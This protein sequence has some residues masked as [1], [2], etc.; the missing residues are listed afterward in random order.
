MQHPREPFSPDDPADGEFPRPRSSPRRP[1]GPAG[2]MPLPA[3]A[4]PPAPLIPPETHHDEAGAPPPPAAAPEPPAGLG[5]PPEEAF[6]PE[7]GFPPDSQVLFEGWEPPYELTDPWWDVSLP[8]RFGDVPVGALA[9]G[10]EE[11]TAGGPGGR[12]TR[13]PRAGRAVL[14]RAPARAGG[15]RTGPGALGWRDPGPDRRAGPGRG[16]PARH[17]RGPDPDRRAHADREHGAE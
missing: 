13:P 17:P 16:H 12:R 9:G 8:P 10:P 5:L 6:P 7:E 11:L 14:G 2:G 15:A 4:A 1:T 3:P